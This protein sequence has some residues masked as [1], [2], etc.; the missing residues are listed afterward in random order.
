MA[1]ENEP[2]HTQRKT[3]ERKPERHRQLG[4]AVKEPVVSAGSAIGPKNRFSP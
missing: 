1:A 4:G 2:P 3:L